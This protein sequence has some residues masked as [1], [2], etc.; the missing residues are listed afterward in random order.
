[1]KRLSILVRTFVSLVL[2]IVLFYRYQELDGHLI[3]RTDDDPIIVKKV[4]ETEPKLSETEPEPTEIQLELIEMELAEETATS[5]TV[6]LTES[7]EQ[8]EPIKQ[9]K[10]PVKSKSKD[11]DDDNYSGFVGRLHIPDACI[12]V[13]MYRGSSQSITDRKDSANIFRWKDYHGEVIADHSN[14]D[15][16]KLLDVEVGFDGYIELKDGSTINIECIATFDGHNTSDILTDEDGNDVMGQSDY[17]MY[18]CVNGWKNVRICLWN[19]SHKN[20]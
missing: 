2:V 6:N 1:M 9:V 13:A 8:T 20:N 15:F 11:V 5:Y 19:V 4:I 14:Q 16:S 10:S 12:D 7:I 17:V 3:L 18:T